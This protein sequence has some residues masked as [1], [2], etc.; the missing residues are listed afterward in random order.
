MRTQIIGFLLEGQNSDGSWG[1]LPGKAGAIEP[2]AYA[3]MSLATEERAS[4]SVQRGVT[5]LRKTQTARGAWAVNTQ[6]SEEAAWATAL[7][8]LALLSFRDTQSACRA[9]AGF[10]VS[11]FA[12][13][14]RPWI[15]RMAD[16]MRSFDA[17]YVEENLRGWKWTPE[18]A[19]WVEPTA[20]AVLFLKGLL[21]SGAI[22]DG[23]GAIGSYRQT[24]GAD[25][26]KQVIAEAESW[27]Y[28]RMCK[29]GGW[30]Y[31]N[32]RVLGEELRPYPLTTAL[33]LMALQNQ[34]SSECQKSLAYLRRAVPAERSAL[35]LCMAVLCLGLY[36]IETEPWMQTATALFGETEF[37][38]NIKT[39][40]LALLAMRAVKGQNVFRL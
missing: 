32:S 34:S 23:S 17:S 37:F 30:N 8:G 10:V 14:P 19:N 2:T 5:F 3:L 26:I 21:Q 12:R 38:Q 4:T 35:A 18:T 24:G 31:G 29:E 33:A 36:E 16:W 11:S 13:H 7:A 15:L 27:L 9:A 40:A 1:Y 6:D 22:A 25:G 28:Q 39:S 20:Y